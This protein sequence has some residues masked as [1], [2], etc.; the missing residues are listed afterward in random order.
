LDLKRI[1]IALLIVVVIYG[2]AVGIGTTLYMTDTIAI[3]ATHNTCPNFKEQIAEER[4]ID[5]EDVPQRD[6]KERTIA[7][8]DGHKLTEEQAFREEYLFWSIWPGVICAVIYL[9]WPAW[10]RIIHRQDEADRA[11]E[12]G[13]LQAG[14]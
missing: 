14:T 9:L 3:G 13:H 6:L 7:C 5:E 12:A 1:G 10:S 8:L 2:T 4:G 11:R